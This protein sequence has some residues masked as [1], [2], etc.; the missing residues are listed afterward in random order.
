MHVARPARKWVHWSHRCGG[1]TAL[2]L[3]LSDR[4]DHGHHPRPVRGGVLWRTLRLQVSTNGSG[5]I[6]QRILVTGGA[7]FI[8]SHLC[9]PLVRD[10]HDILCVDN[11]F[12]GRKDNLVNLLSSSRFEVMRHD[13]AFRLYV[14]VDE[15]CNLAGLPR[16]VPAWPNRA[17]HGACPSSRRPDRP[18]PRLAAQSSD[19]QCRQHPAQCAAVDLGI[20]PD[21]DPARQRD[22]YRAAGA[23]HRRSR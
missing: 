18:A 16:R 19:R 4:L 21:T 15:I 8:G 11:C 10:R 13:V 2:D 12:T 22:L 20:H 23:C 7:G 6:P 3:G 17:S 5:S 1:G 9:E 14:E